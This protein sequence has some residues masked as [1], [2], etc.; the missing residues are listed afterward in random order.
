MYFDACTIGGSPFR[1][2]STG[3]RFNW[4]DSPLTMGEAQ[5]NLLV[6]YMCTFDTRVKPLFTLVNFW[7]KYQNVRIAEETISK[8]V[9]HC[10]AP[11]PEALEWLVMLFLIHKRIL[12]SVRKICQ[13]PHK[14]LMINEKDVSFSADPNFA[15]EWKQSQNNSRDTD[16]SSPGFLVSVLRL[17]QG[18]FTFYSTNL[19]FGCHVLNPKDGELIKRIGNNVHWRSSTLSPQEALSLSSLQVKEH[20]PEFLII[21][22]YRIY[23][24][25]P[26]YISWRLS[27][28]VE[29]WTNSTCTK[30]KE[31][32]QRLDVYLKDSGKPNQKCLQSVI[33]GSDQA[34]LAQI[35]IPKSTCVQNPETPLQLQYN[36]ICQ[37]VEIRED[38]IKDTLDIINALQRAFTEL[39]FAGRIALL[40]N[41]YLGL[42]NTGS[43]VLLLFAYIAG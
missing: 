11:E 40:R 41:Y 32:A 24:M 42:R 28:C 31:A 43:N 2:I 6:Q 5:L 36:A 10:N 17:L 16:P 23:M 29:T 26:L 21:N 34:Y 19:E 13:R 7:A 25:H 38:E 12:P 15:E 1:E 30:M 33:F 9:H 3:Y 14:P 39:H 18:F 22:N 8:Q 27:F 4:S 20:R 35:D 37:S